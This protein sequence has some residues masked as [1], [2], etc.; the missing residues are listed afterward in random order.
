VVTIIQEPSFKKHTNRM[1]G[2]TIKLLVIGDPGVGKSLLSRV[3]DEE[4]VVGALSPDSFTKQITTPTGKSKT[5]HVKNSTGQSKTITLDGETIKLQILDRDMKREG[6]VT[7][8]NPDDDDHVLYRRVHGFIV[9]Y[10]VTDQESFNNVKQWLHEID[11]Y[12]SENIKIILVGNKSDLISKRVVSNEIAQEFAD[13]L[14]IELRETSAKNATNVEETFMTIAAQIS[15]INRDPSLFNPAA[16]RDEN[17]DGAMGCGGS[18][19]VLM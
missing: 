1:R 15:Q 8:R 17:P 12:A 10:D 13:N 16:A 5:V 6:N 9:L 7:G 11:R 3:G 18:G 2:D 19:C 4:Q 14:G